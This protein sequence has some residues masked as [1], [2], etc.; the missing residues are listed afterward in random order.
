LISPIFE[1]DY[2]DY[3]KKDFTDFKK[4]FTLDCNHRLTPAFAS[5]F[6]VNDTIVYELFVKIAVLFA[7]AGFL[8]LA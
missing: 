3:F 8:Y 2:T 4:P 6:K 1:E 5:G 7:N